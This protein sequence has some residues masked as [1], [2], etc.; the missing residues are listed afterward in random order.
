MKL[1]DGKPI[2]E[3]GEPYMRSCWRC[4]DC[5]QHLKKVN[6]LHWCF[7]C[8]KYWIF[9]K[10][11]TEIGSDEKLAEFLKGMGLKEGQSTS[12]IDKGY[13]IWKITIKPMKNRKRHTASAERK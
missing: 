3:K 12:T 11:L 1:V 7:S 5:H 4:N 2:V 8:G 10:F 6:M 9:D 13:R